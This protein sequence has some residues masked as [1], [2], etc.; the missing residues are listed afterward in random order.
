MKIGIAAIF[1]NECEFILEWIAYHRAIGIDYFL[2][3]DNESEDG[4]A[5]LLGGL[6]KAGFIQAVQFQNPIDQRPQLPAYSHMLKICPKDVDLLAFI[7]ADEFIL[8]LDGSDSIRSFFGR[9][10]SDEAVSALALNWA[11]YGSCGHVFA[12]NELVIDR[13]TKMAEKDFGVNNHYKSIVRPARVDFFENPH[14]A[15]L[16]GGRF[17]D[18]IGNDVVYH[19]RHGHG[20]SRDV[21]WGGARV[22]HYAV[23]SLEEFLVGKSRKGS[24]S[25]A[26]RVKHADYFYRHDK[27]DVVSEIPRSLHSRVLAELELVKA[28]LE[29]VRESEESRGSDKPPALKRIMKIIGF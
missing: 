18:S 19:E 7:D 12:T 1:K 26:S 22:N 20:L 14:H 9:I 2:I 11:T 27:N 5:E 25:R 4:S 8:P 13:F 3:A 24:A 21:V 23:K 28:G 15:K 10:F 6:E 29:R 16:I 17:V